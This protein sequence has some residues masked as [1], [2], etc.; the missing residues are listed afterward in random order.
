MKAMILMKTALMKTAGVSFA[1]VAVGMFM[2]HAPTA[3]AAVVGLWQFNEASGDALDSSGNGNTGTLEGINIG[4]AASKSGFGSAIEIFNDNATHSYVQALGNFSLQVGANAGDPWSFTMWANEEDDGFGLYLATYGRFFSQTSPATGLT[5]F[6]VDSAANGDEQI[7]IWSEQDGVWQ[8]GT[9]VLPPLNT[10][11]HYAFVYD[12]TDLIMYL[13]GVEEFRAVVGSQTLDFDGYD[14]AVQ[15]GGQSNFDFTRNWSGRLDDFAIF[16]EALSPGDLATVMSGD[17]SSFIAPLPLP[18][19]L[20]WH[21]GDSGDWNFAVNW[22]PLGVPNTNESTAIFGS[23]TA[24]AATIVTD[25]PVTV[26]A[27]E[28]DRAVPFAITGTSGIT[29]QANAGDASI[30]VTGGS[31]THE[32]QTQVTLA[33]NTTV[34]VASGMVVEFDNAL[35]LGAQTLTKVGDGEV[36]FNS[37]LND[38]ANGTVVGQAGTISGQRIGGV[39]DNQSATVAPGASAGT[40]R[41]EDNFLQGSAGTLA[42]ELAST[43]GGMFD[44]LEV[45][46]AAALDGFLEISLLDGFMPMSGDTFDVL[47]ASSIIDNGLSLSGEAGFSFSLEST[48]TILRLTFDGVGL[49][50]DFDM[51]GT[52]D[53]KDF[54]LWQRGGSPNPLSQSDLADWEANYGMTAPLSASATAVPEPT[55]GMLTLFA[56]VGLLASARRRCNKALSVAKPASA[57]LVFAI[58]LSSLMGL[59]TAQGALLGLWRFDEGSGLTSADASGRGHDGDLA[60]FPPDPNG[61]ANTQLPSWIAGSPGSPTGALRFN[62]GPTEDPHFNGFFVPD[63]PVFDAPAASD[64]I[65]LAAW[66]SSEELLEDT[67]TGKW[68][69]WGRII[70]RGN[71]FFYGDNLDTV[72]SLGFTFVKDGPPNQIHVYDDDTP[73]LAAATSLPISAD[74]STAPEWTHV[75]VTYDS[76]DVKFYLNGSLVFTSNQPGSLGS[77]DA[78]F[79]NIGNEKCYC[80]AWVGALDDVALFDEALSEAAIGTIMGGD[81]S[82]FPL[83]SIV[84]WATDGM[85]T[86]TNAGNWDPLGVPSGIA[87]HAI[88]GD[89]TSGPTTVIL[90]T[91]ITVRDITFQHGESYSIGGANTLTL[92]SGSGNTS[93]TV[94]SVA[95]P[96]VSHQL[97]AHVVLATDLDVAIAVT[98][99]LDINNQL[100]LGAFNLTKTGSGTLNINN[101]VTSDGGVIALTAGVI[102]G[103]GSIEGDLDNSGGTM[104]PGN[105]PG[106]F[107]IGGDY[108]QSGDGTLLIELAG[109]VRGSQ[110]DVLNVYGEMV[111]VGGTLEIVLSGGFV[112][113]VG[114]AFDI[115]DFS[116]VTGGFQNVI[117]PG[118]FVWDT[119][120]LLVDGSLVVSAIPEPSTWMIA[121]VAMT[122][123]L[124]RR[125]RS[126]LN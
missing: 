34:D 126:E 2:I 84:T 69:N 63:D 87:G 88:F 4:R 15:I 55:T 95:G 39:L 96:G 19:T 82:A 10:W 117:L 118:G 107:T 66:V 17:F 99:G 12:S 33:S 36:R 57:M 67:A 91:D 11:V 80:R 58:G 8:Y 9:G 23:D 29:L 101:V 13:N 110:Y 103:S 81:F 104:A 93:I 124:R 5:G 120:S 106:V 71:Y 53:G 60:F 38:T 75:A 6:Y 76:T 61:A 73:G 47:T 45:V 56:F 68:S 20:T 1:M 42:I 113:S 48:N 21:S 65:T 7:Y 97:Q 44:L 77:S 109:N 112:P 37:N 32:F 24:T 25:Q 121:V 98:Y 83:P 22:A 116:S 92:E 114:D 85:G 62:I 119:S 31:A 102:S 3:P 111:L 78:E 35:D 59:S 28:I 52:V 122:G 46:G 89:V 79:L 26:K 16:N 41:V 100:D 18:T 123:F 51:N 86:W 90:D 72:D 50:G 40:L 108:L 105:S 54:L 30:L 14:G 70:T 27:I 43:A 125:R 64:A 74:S 49:T 115:L 94:V